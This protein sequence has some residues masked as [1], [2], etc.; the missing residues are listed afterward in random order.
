MGCRVEYHLDERP[1]ARRE[2]LVD[3]GDWRVPGHA[4]GSELT[5][6]LEERRGGAHARGVDLLDQDRLGPRVADPEPMRH[7]AGG[8][9]DGAEIELRFSRGQV[10]ADGW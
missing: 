2:R 6:A 8:H 5:H 3:G 10:A 7:L 4:I 1:L 9:R